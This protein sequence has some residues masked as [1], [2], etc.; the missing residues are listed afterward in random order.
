MG[1]QKCPRGSEGGWRQPS[2]GR[3]RSY[4]VVESF[5][6]S[7]ERRL[8]RRTGRKIRQIH[9]LTFQTAEEIL[10]HGVV[11]RVAA[12]RHALADIVPPQCVTVALRGVLYAAVAVENETRCRP[13]SA[14]RHLQRGDGQRCVDAV[15]KGVSDNLFGTEIL[16]NGGVEPA[17]AGRNVGNVADPDGVRF[18][19]VKL[20]LQQVRRGRVAV[21]RVGRNAV[22][23]AA[24]GADAGPTHQAVDALAAAAE[25]RAQKAVE[26]VESECRILRVKLDQTAGNSLVFKGS[27]AGTVYP[28][29]VVTAAGDFE[30][31]A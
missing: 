7:E 4:G 13:L 25:I 18:C 8:R 31:A 6:V 11:I 26:A 28:P 21:V 22:G 15:G 29:G 24:R 19:D 20:P 17:L 1:V 10:G 9:Q 2:E 27:R 14:H 12:A 5:N 30:R 23:P 16:D 3:M